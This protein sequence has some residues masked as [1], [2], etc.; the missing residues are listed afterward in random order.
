MLVRLKTNHLRG[1]NVQ[2][3]SYGTWQC[4]LLLIT[5]IVTHRNFSS[6]FGLKSTGN[7]KTESLIFE[8]SV[9]TFQ[10]VWS[11][12][13]L[14]IKAAFRIDRKS[15]IM[16]LWVLLCPVAGAYL[17]N[18]PFLLLQT[19]LFK[20]ERKNDV[21]CLFWSYICCFFYRH[22]HTFWI[23]PFK[24]VLLQTASCRVEKKCDAICLF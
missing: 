6:K 13:I 10:P 24:F 12:P 16:W 18:S 11:E 17:Q 23:L 1:C 14:N 8:V 3:A 4:F 20:A 2:Q 7:F 9:W 5:L 22:M 21:M 15:Y 19:A